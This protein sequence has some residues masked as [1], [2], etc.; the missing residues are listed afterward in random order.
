[1]HAFV[2]VHT[3]SL[4]TALLMGSF[5]WC[6]HNPCSCNVAL[7]NIAPRLHQN[8]HTNS[9]KEWKYGLAAC[10]ASAVLGG[11]AVLGL[12]HVD[13]S[14]AISYSAG[15]AVLAGGLAVAAAHPQVT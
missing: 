3:R 6:R 8:G 2:R 9:L 4:A 15:A 7:I 5:R 11:L 10:G 1:M 13:I 12:Q 14:T